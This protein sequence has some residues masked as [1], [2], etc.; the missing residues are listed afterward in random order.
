[1]SSTTHA[2]PAAVAQPGSR[3]L[4]LLTR[5]E[6]ALYIRERAGVFWG[7]AFPVLLLIIFGSIPGFCSSVSPSL[8]H[9]S[10]LAAYVPILIAFTMAI[11]AVNAMPPVLAGYREKGYLRRLATTPVGP[12]RVLL[13]QFLVTITV[14]L[15]ALILLLAISRLAY[16]VPLPRQAG[17]YILAVLL[18][19]AALLAIGLFVAALASTGRA[20]NAL[21]AVLFF[22]MMFFAG[23][24]LPMAAMPA[25]LRHIAYATPLGAGVQALQDATLGHF[26][27]PL[28]LLVLA[29]Y[30]LVFG[31]AAARLFQWE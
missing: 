31:V 19:A 2:R 12:A 22:P 14:I 8:P 28:Q 25:V 29:A 10:V 6:A 23:L 21:G 16:S 26:P 18:T 3:A 20:A 30:A 15:T 13:A 5:T 17:G 27:H 24:W 11:Q 1:M 9:L 7:L 4:L